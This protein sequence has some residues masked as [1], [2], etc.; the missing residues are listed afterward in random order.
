MGHITIGRVLDAAI[1]S[2]SVEQAVASTPWRTLQLGQLVPVEF[3]D[4]ELSYVGS[5]L[6]GVVYRQG[7]AGGVV[8]A[9][10]TLQWIAGNLVR[11]TRT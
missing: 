10:L 9:T 4:I 5:D 2:V 3:D 1:D 8:V 11:V 6:T 7:G